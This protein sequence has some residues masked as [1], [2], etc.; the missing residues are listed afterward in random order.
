MDY[1]V[2]GVTKSWTRLRDLHFTSLQKQR[3]ISLNQQKSEIIGTFPIKL[4]KRQD[5]SLL[6]L[7]FFFSL[8]NFIQLVIFGCAGSSLLCRLFSSCG[9]PGLLSGCGAVACFVAK[10]NLQGSR[11]SAV[12]AHG[13]LQLWLP[14]SRAQARQLWHEGLVALQHVGSSQTR[15]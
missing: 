11:A 6:L 9:K 4:G 2:H 5:C 1:I 15:D 13:I 7:S 14:G 10:H 3:Q 8:Y 12:A